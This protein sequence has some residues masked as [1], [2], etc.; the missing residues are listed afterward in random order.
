M[1]N[2]YRSIFII[3]TAAVA[4]G[5]AKAYTEG[6]NE[7]G[8][9]YLK[10]WMSL[11]HPG[12]E[13]SWKGKTGENGIYVLSEREGDGKE[14][15]DSG[16]AI[17]DCTTYDLEGNIT[18]YTN[19]SVARQLGAYSPADYYGPKVW[20]TFDQ[21]IPA[22]VQDAIVGMKT[23]GSKKVIIPSWM[24][25]YSSYDSADEY[26]NHSSEYSNT[27]YEFTVRDFT[28]SIDVWQN[29]SIERY[30]VKNYGDLK[31]FSN[32]TTGFYFKSLVTDM[33]A[34]T[35]TFPQDTAIYINYTGKLLN[36]LVFDTTDER[37][38]KDNG[39]YDSGKT[40]SPVKI[41]W[42]DEY[43]DLTMGDDASSVISG[44]AMTLWRMKYVPDNT[45]WKDRCIG[46]FNSNLGYGYSGSGSS[47]PAYASLIFEIEIVD[48]PEE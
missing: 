20:L 44:F 1:K 31:A 33:P 43:T 35:T 32:D 11:N 10:A 47:I 40:Y 9:R 26:L 4:A 24:M 37:V 22:G 27:I 15:T 21:T 12:V 36:G 23:G 8:E 34:D 25:S 16:Y 48:E 18:S 7:A 14:V 39:I 5:C 2:I 38:A 17:V 29:D 28:D 45:A 46:I 6:A 41:A 3:A 42:G 13:A 19:E 30:I